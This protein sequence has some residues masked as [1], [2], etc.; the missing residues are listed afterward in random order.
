MMNIDDY[1]LSLDRKE[2]G[3]TIDFVS[4][5]HSDHIAAA[6]SSKRILAS[7]VTKE[8][9]QT[10]NAIEPQEEIEVPH[11]LS[12]INAG[13]ILGSKQ[14]VMN[15]ESKGVRTVYTGDF[16]MQKSRTC[17]MIDVVQADAVIMDSTYFQPDVVFDERQEV[18][19]T[20]RYWTDMKLN[21][22]IVLF[23]TY[24]LG[25]AQE[26]VSIL[27]GNGILPIVTK[28]ISRV[29]NVYKKNGVKLDYASA[30]EG[31]D[32][33]QTLLRGNFVGI[34]E[35]SLLNS[36]AVT[37]AEL[38]NK[39]VYTAVAT[40]FAKMMKFN[41]DIQFPLSDH[42]DFKQCMDYINATGA[43]KVFTYGSNKLDLASSLVDKG[44][45][46]MPY[47]TAQLIS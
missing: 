29:N 7:S 39:K 21:D 46:A 35:N 14:I 30:Y 40:G 34:V 26:L 13:H 47:G 23:G 42:A 8:L 37:L 44:Y 2:K 27:N 43:K 25:K 4:H 24:A 9:L 19:E 12:M 17:E 15:D 10:I 33:Y 36:M 28:K 18:E 1:A 3:S 16:Q 41:T 45:D 6:K 11:S 38:Y 20:I 22:G 5:A 32:D 31:K